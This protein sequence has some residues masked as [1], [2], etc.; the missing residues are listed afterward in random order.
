MNE[1]KKVIDVSV[2]KGK[3]STAEAVGKNIKIIDYV[4]QNHDDLNTVIS[5]LSKY[6]SN[7]SMYNHSKGNQKNT[8]RTRDMSIDEFIK[9]TRKITRGR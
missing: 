2:S 6:N 5:T 7:Y 3:V 1:T 8:K 4:E 9:D